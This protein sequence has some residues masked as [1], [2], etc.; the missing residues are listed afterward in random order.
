MDMDATYF[1]VGIKGTGMSSL[2]LILHDKGCKVMGSDIDKYTFTQRG[3]EQAGIKILPFNADNIKPG[4]IIVAGNAFNDDQEEIAK[5][6][7]MG[8]K[9][10]RYPEVVE[11][12][13]EETT[14]IGVAGAHGKTST[15]GLLA[16]VMSGVS[17][18]SY[19]VGDGSGKGTPDARFFVFEADEY[20][21]H[22]VAYHPD[23]TI[24]T[25]IDFDHPDYFTG[26][27]DVCDAFE[28]LARQT[29]KGIFAWGEDKNLRK[30]N[31]N[32]PIYYYGTEDNDDFVAKNI[33]RTTTGSSFDVYF[34]DQFLGN[35]E[36]H[37]FGEHNVLN[38]LAVIA[39]SYFEKIDLGKV[40][41]ELL[42]FKGVKRRFTE[43][44]VADMVIIDDYAH[45]PTEIRATLDAARQQYPNKK[46][47]AVFQPHTFT[48]TIALM[49]DFAKSLN[50]A[51]QVYLTDIFG[52]IRENSGNVSS[53]DLGK[54]IT[55]G[56]EVLKLDNMS[57][58]LDYHDAV[59]IFMGAGDIQKYER[60]YEQLLSELSLNK[61]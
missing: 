38:T 47:I 10:M 28:T 58:L 17:P 21:R 9:V 27:D 18:T 29:K 36:T 37:L 16:H 30:L 7:E 60:V 2:A 57:P 50:I 12:I 4:M 5:A 25:N 59:V 46:L 41:Q 48:R 8:L 31:A 23:Y 11:M 39:V 55:K 14:S 61:N 19:L 24:M 42:T 53:A 26:I 1:F 6:K 49:D 44:T 40:K 54:K 56:G 32:V 22:F 52:S 35:F 15:T 34:H 51:D 13:I 33:K 45:H 3:L 43:K 20:R